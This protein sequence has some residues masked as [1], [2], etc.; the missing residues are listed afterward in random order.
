MLRYTK[1]NLNTP[2]PELIEG[3]DNPE[4]PLQFIRNSEIEFEMVPADIDSMNE[5]QLNEYADFLDYLWTK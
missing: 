5:D 4:T 1:E 2:F 3:A